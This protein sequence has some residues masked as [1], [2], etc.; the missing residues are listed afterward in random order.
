MRFS[1]KS[2]TDLCESTF[3]KVFEEKYLNATCSSAQWQADLESKRKQIDNDLT[4]IAFTKDIDQLNFMSVDYLKTLNLSTT[5]SNWHEHV[6][7]LKKA[8]EFK[9]QAEAHRKQQ[10]KQND[11]KVEALAQPVNPSKNEEKVAKT[12]NYE[13]LQPTDYLYS[14]TFKILDATYEQMMELTKFFKNNGIRFHSIAKE[15]KVRG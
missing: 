4:N 7:Q 9:A 12:A 13:Q 2:C 8:E 6:E 3:E 15:K 10:E 5:L 1:K 14:P 11:T